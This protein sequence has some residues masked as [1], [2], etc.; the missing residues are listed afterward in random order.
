MGARVQ[1]IFKQTQDP[2]ELRL[3]LEVLKVLPVF[4]SFTFLL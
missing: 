2:Q 1:T 3:M 4:A